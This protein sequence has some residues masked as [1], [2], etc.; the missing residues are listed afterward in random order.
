MTRQMLLILVLGILTGC[1]GEYTS[2]DEIAIG[3]PFSSVSQEQMWAMMVGTW[4]GDQP[5]D[6]GG[7][8]QWLMERNLDGT[9][10][11]QFR[12][13]GPDGSFNESIEVGDWGVSGPIYFSSFRG[14]EEDGVLSPA[15]PSDPYYYDAYLIIELNTEEFVYEHV[16]TGNRYTVRRVPDSFTMPDRS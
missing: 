11:I 16:T 2:R 13:T 6:G 15:D 8:K 9:Y 1:E 12:T 5:A 14:W 4:Y 3:K 10:T 7:R